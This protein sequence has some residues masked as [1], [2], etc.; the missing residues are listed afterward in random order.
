MCGN[1]S[2]ALVSVIQW[3]HAHYFFEEGGEVFWVLEM[4]TVA[5]FLYIDV[6]AAQEFL[7]TQY[8]D[9]DIVLRRGEADV[10]LEETAE[11]GVA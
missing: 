6:G 5:D 8:L 3:I 10:F 7:G 2:K 4:Q 11:G 1:S 9:G